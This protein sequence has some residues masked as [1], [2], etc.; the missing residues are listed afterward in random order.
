MNGGKEKVS[1]VVYTKVWQ[2]P[3]RIAHWLMFLSV[4][5]LGITGYL[6]GN[7][8][9]SEP[10]EASKIYTFGKI[11]FIHFTAAYVLLTAFLIRLYWGLVGNRFSRWLLMLPITGKRIKAIFSEAGDLLMPKGKLRVYTGH[12]PL[13][14]VIYLIV[15]LGVLF[16]I[17][18][19]FTLHAQAHY[20]PFWRTI[21]AWGLGLF[22]NNLNN[23]HFLH[24]LMLWF[25]ILFVMVHLYLVVYTVI[26]SR[27]TEID[28]M[29]SGR[30]F[31][32]REELHET[33]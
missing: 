27:T 7:P 2:T 21:A 25:F 31:V 32:F 15:Y 17:I 14:N 6:I 4:I 1:E 23:V 20:T 24:H 5:T 10:T 29:V 3:I 19:G 28:T 12:S 9:F 16:S 8:S 13:A 33:E 22:G 30:K 26:V 18:T 11:R